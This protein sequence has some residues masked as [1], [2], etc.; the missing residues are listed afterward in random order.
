MSMNEQRAGYVVE[1]G[2]T[3]QIFTNPVNKITE[4]YITGRFG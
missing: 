2:V 4:D 1:T 3:A